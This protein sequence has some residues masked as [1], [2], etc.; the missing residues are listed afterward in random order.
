[1]AGAFGSVA[2]AGA[3]GTGSIA[4][5]FVGAI[6]STSAA[7]LSSRRPLKAAWRI[8]PSPVHPANSISATSV[9][10]SQCA[11]RV[12]AGSVLRSNGVLSRA[13][14]FSLGMMAA[15]VLAEKPVPMRPTKASL[16]S[17]NTPPSSERNLPPVSVQPPSTTS[18]VGRHLALVQLSERPER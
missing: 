5:C 9:G 11:L 18:C 4:F 7:G 8:E 16:S 17:R 10:S 14:A 6:A 13:A 12:S 3:A 1:M 2:F 15:T